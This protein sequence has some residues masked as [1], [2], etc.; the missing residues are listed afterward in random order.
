MDWKNI[1]V[2]AVFN[3]SNVCISVDRIY[4]GNGDYIPNYNPLAQETYEEILDPSL[5]ATIKPGY[6]KL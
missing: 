3:N 4:A 2:W 5:K 6:L 1:R